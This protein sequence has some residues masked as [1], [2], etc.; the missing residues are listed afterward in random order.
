MHFISHSSLDKTAALDLRDRLLARGYDAQQIFLD[1]DEDSGI[2]AGRKWEQVL[3][4][5]LKDC[6]AMIVLC[7]PHWQKS[8][9]CFAELVYAKMAGKEVFPVVLADCDLSVAS[10]HQAV[11]VNRDGEAAYERLLDALEARN[12]GP[13]DHPTE[14]ICRQANR[15]IESQLHATAYAMR[16]IP[17]L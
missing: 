16:S 15:G 1:S 11:F 14:F 5:R 3:Y 4:E 7:S 17:P 12:L 8:K 6:R 13:K 2:A 10:E 9:W